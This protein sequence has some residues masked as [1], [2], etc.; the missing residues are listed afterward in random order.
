MK[1]SLRR[2]S[3]FAMLVVF[4]VPGLV[5]ADE[6]K[7]E[8]KKAVEAKPNKEQPTPEDQKVSG[9][10]G[11]AL[12]NSRIEGYDISIQFKSGVATLTGRVADAAAKKQAQDI[13][14]EVDGVTRVDNQ[15][16]VEV[17]VKVD[18]AEKPADEKPKAVKKEAAKKPK[19]PA[20]A[21][22]IEALAAPFVEALADKLDL[23]AGNAQADAQLKQWIPQFTEQFRPILTME[24]NFI[25]Q[26]CDLTPEQRPKIKAA[27]EA[28]VTEAARKM[29][30]MQVR[31]M[32]VAVAQNSQ[33]DPRRII[34]DA[35]AKV[36]K[37]TLTPEQMA[38]Y[39]E[40]ATK[41]T[42]LRKRAAILSVVA[43]LDS[44]MCLTVEQ[45]D[46]ITESI[47]SGWQDKWEQWLMMS[48]YGGQYFPMVPDQ[49]VV[50]HLNA[51]QKSVWSG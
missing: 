15:L 5:R 10:I 43:L 33:P 9:K 28:S 49:F 4:F 13:V 31:Q 38:K 23:N 17:K 32:R 27:G 29:A 11:E 45:R 47:S 21:I 25:R 46:K 14:S 2:A 51:E 7:V 35:L 37:E 8:D 40:E 24:L 26:M 34:R 18:P 6:P 44:T 50:T 20:A 12:T 36:L 22:E 30:E 1:T 19:A 41:R 3:A 48:A 42:A 39:T 16:K